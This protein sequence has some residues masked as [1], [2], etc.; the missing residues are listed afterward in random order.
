MSSVQD[1]S[2]HPYQLKITAGLKSVSSRLPN[3]PKDIFNI[4]YRCTYRIIILLFIQNSLCN[5]HT[6]AISCLNQEF[7]ILNILKWWQ[8]WKCECKASKKVC[9]YCSRRKTPDST[10]GCLSEALGKLGFWEFGWGRVWGKGGTEEVSLQATWD[11][12][13]QIL[14]QLGGFQVSRRGLERGAKSKGNAP[15][16]L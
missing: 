3:I 6:E 4:K 15:C 14:S 1:L 10:W 13:G 12:G 11:Q 5:Q 7:K 2:F 16:I 9:I 8:G